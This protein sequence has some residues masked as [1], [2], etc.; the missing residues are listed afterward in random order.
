MRES[1][2]MYIILLNPDCRVTDGWARR[3]VETAEGSSNIGIVA[4]K[5]LQFDGLID[6]TGHNYSNWPYTI[7]DRGQGEPDNGQ[8]DNLRELVSCNFG[9]VMIK[10]DL[11]RQTGLL[12]ERFF[13]YYEDVEYCH[14][15]R[16]GGWRTV[17]CPESIVY[18]QRHGSGHNRWMDESRRYLPY[19]LRKYYPKQLLVKWYLQK[20]KAILAGLK[21]RDLAYASSNFRAMVDGVW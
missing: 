14:R 3:L 16:T 8:Y 10:R 11:I 15:A 4:P 9:C 1:K 17:Y 5:L 18:H 7:A 6:S 13:L 2:G 19:I 20:P 21:N 12:D